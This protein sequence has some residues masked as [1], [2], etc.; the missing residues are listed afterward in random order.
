[1]SSYDAVEYFFNKKT[2]RVVG[3]NAALR[4]Y[5]LSKPHLVPC[6]ADGT[7]LR[8]DTPEE[9]SEEVERL[10]Q[11]LTD[12]QTEIEILKEQI[13]SMESDDTEQS[14]E[15]PEEP[16]DGDGPTRMD[17]LVDAIGQMEDGNPDHFRKDGKPYV[18]MLRTFSGVEDATAEEASAAFDRY[19]EG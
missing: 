5:A 12:A 1:M 11:Q 13:R 17:L 7:P 6:E 2:G 14:P 4:D 18:E 3:A 9:S 8:V 10:K 19:M 16:Q 15:T